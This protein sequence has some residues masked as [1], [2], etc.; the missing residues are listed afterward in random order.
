M[1]F[2][3]EEDGTALRRFYLVLWSKQRTAVVVPHVK[4]PL[5]QPHSSRWGLR[6]LCSCYHCWSPGWNLLPAWLWPSNICCG[7][8][9]EWIS[10]YKI[11]S[12]PCHSHFQVKINTILKW[13]LV[14]H[15][16]SGWRHKENTSAGYSSLV[17]RN[18]AWERS[19]EMRR[20]WE[21]STDTRG[22]VSGDFQS[23]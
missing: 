1:T 12:P 15:N 20:H 11:S 10:R 14:R 6:R 13:L 21:F 23:W 17:Y 2:H 4:L 19:Q 8:L 16:S 3:R 22:R 5:R 7:R 18:E 9:G